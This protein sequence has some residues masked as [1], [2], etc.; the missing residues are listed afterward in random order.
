MLDPTRVSIV[1]ATCDVNSN[2]GGRQELVIDGDRSRV[3]V[4]W[5]LH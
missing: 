2:W 4:D 3:E 5:D 1:H